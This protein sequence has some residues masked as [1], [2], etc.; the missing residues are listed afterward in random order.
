MAKDQ[1]TSGDI[2]N[3]EEQQMELYLRPQT[4]DQNLGQKL[5]KNEMS[6]F[7]KTERHSE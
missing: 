1:V 3:P 2:E 7:I 4:L 6:I 5:V